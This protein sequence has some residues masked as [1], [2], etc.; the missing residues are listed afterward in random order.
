MCT[1]GKG[2]RA[3]YNLLL[4]PI[5]LKSNLLTINSKYMPILMQVN[6]SYMLLLSIPR[7][8]LNWLRN[9]RKYLGAAYFS[10]KNDPAL[11]IDIP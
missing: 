9:L 4:N 10:N 6:T 5:R 2:T 1:F 3:P 11:P 8:S 7:I